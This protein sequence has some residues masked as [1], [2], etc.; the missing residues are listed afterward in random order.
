MSKYTLQILPDY[1]SIGLT[2]ALKV[3]RVKV[4]KPVVLM[5]QVANCSPHPVAQAHALTLQV[6]MRP[7]LVYQHHVDRKSLSFD[8]FTN[9]FRG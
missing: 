6:G 9:G 5:T 8:M 1:L 4:R 2:E 3:L 7:N